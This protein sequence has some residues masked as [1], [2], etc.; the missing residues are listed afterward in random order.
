MVLPIDADT[1]RLLAFERWLPDWLA[2]HEPT[3]GAHARIGMHPQLCRPSPERPAVL[4]GLCV[5]R[6]PL[7]GFHAVLRRLYAAAAEPSWTT[8]PL[9][10]V[11]ASP[12]D[13][14]DPVLPG[15]EVLDARTWQAS[16]HEHG[17]WTTGV[18]ARL[19]RRLRQAP[20]APHRDYLDRVIDM[21]C[22]ALDARVD[23]TDAARRGPRR[24]CSDVRL[25]WSSTDADRAPGVVRAF[26]TQRWLV[27]TKNQRSPA[28]ELAVHELRERLAHEPS[29]TT[30]LLVA[31]HGVTSGARQLLAD[32]RAGGL[33]VFA[34]D[35]ATLAGMVDS[36]ERA[37]RDGKDGAPL[38]WPSQAWH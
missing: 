6:H 15:V 33:S 25:R 23:S 8:K 18:A 4:L 35:D 1:A 26:T 21:F 3:M 38:P 17:Q 27:E 37:C 24:R 7:L 9:R 28:G 5:A 16:W 10:L 2:T 13:L 11:L 14:G 36:R 22:F 30:G 34:G 29:S 31:P 12:D 32:L 20:Y 19:T